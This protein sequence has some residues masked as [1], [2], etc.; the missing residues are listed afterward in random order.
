MIKI[1]PD[2]K[3]CG[4]VLN[5]GWLWLG[6]AYI[7]F[8]FCGSCIRLGDTVKGFVWA[9]GGRQIKNVPAAKEKV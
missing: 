6:D 2:C 9:K 5:E 3:K 8:S 4:K 7:C 1:M